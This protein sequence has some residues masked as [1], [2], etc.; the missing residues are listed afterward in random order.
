M[1]EPIGGAEAS[2]K[3]LKLGIKKEVLGS[4]A[5]SIFMIALILPQ[6]NSQPIG[7]MLCTRIRK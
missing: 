5:A 1:N 4:Y 2:D 6:L 3:L 7:G